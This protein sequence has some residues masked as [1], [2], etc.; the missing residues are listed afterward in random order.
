MKM[1]PTANAYNE[2]GEL[3]FVGIADHVAS[4]QTFQLDV[5]VSRAEKM[6]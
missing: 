2:F 5:A 1:V 3:A 6:L 4:L